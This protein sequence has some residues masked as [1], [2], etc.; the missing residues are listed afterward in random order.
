MKELSN[1]NAILKS[2][3]LY[4]PNNK[5]TI[6]PVMNP[7]SGEIDFRIDISNTFTTSYYTGN[8]CL[9]SVRP[10][11]D[12]RYGSMTVSQKQLQVLKDWLNKQEL[13]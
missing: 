4:D 13:G 2:L 11:E 7:T 9:S 12:Y 6:A 1:L 8:V 3:S 10:A 5:L